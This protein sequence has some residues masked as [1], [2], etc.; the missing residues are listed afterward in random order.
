MLWNLRPW[1]DAAHEEKNVSALT[2][3]DWHLPLFH[4]P[5]QSGALEVAPHGGHTR[6]A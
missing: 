5:R 4:A 3:D 2:N 6:I 1:L